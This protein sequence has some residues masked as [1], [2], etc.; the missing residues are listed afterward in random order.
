MRRLSG[1][2]ALFLYNETPTQHMHTLKV[3]I[4]DPS[5]NPEGYSFAHE[6]EKLAARL[7]RLPPFRWRVVPTPLGLHHPVVVD[8]EVDMDFHLRRAAV[9]A[10]GGPRELG[11]L[12]SEIASRPLDRSRPLWELWMVEGLEGGRVASVSKIHHTLADGVASVELL[13]RLL[14]HEPAEEVPHDAPPWAPEPIPPPLARLRMALRDLARFLPRYVAKITRAAREA[15]RRHAASLARHL[16]QPPA[17]Y[18]CPDIPVNRVI[19]AQ[20]RFAFTDLPLAEVSAVRRA[21]GATVNDVV[22]AVI[23]GAMRSWLARRGDLPSVPL[24]G[25]VPVSTRTPEE[26]GTWGNRVAAMNV[27]VHSEIEDPVERLRATQRATRAAKQDLEDTRGARLS[28]WLELFPPFVSQL[29]FSRLPTWMKRHGRPS[30]ANLTIS[31]VPGPKE[32]LWYGRSRLAAFYSVGP[33]LEG[34]GL[35]I[36]VWSYVDRLA[37]GLIACRDAVRDPWEIAD[38]IRASLEELGKAAA[39]APPAAEASAGEASA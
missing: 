13:N 18:S 27:A 20:R 36:T 16:E 28:D 30:Q 39:A 29:V 25:Q 10:P 21:F 5:E 33:V 17:T 11:D 3:G 32:P 7:H 37:F 34:I 1:I 38:A 31:N 26:R 22:V 8:A 12:I 23:A 14:T 9:P 15:H 4:I 35:N 2:D 6:K 24:V 19:S